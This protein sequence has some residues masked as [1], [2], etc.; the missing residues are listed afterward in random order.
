[1]PRGAVAKLDSDAEA[2]YPSEKVL[3]GRLDVEV[4]PYTD[5]SSVTEDGGSS[6]ALRE[7]LALTTRNGG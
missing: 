4:L 6:D 7:A 1:M 5:V 3:S 2:A